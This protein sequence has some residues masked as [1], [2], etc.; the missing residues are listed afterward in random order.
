MY[1]ANSIQA[2]NLEQDAPPPQVTCPACGFHYVHI[3]GVEVNQG[4]KAVFV[5]RKGSHAAG[6]GPATARGSIVTTTF[7]CENGHKFE[8]SLA[9][10]KGEVFIRVTVCGEVDVASSAPELWRD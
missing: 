2:P 10:H 7:W 1:T 4:G 5:D 8:H 3:A 9:F 6:D